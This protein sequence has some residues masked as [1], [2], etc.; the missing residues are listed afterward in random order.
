MLAPGWL[1]LVIRKGRL[2]SLGYTARDRVH[3]PS[4]IAAEWYNAATGEKKTVGGAGRV[5]AQFCDESEAKRL[6][7]NR[8]ADYGRG[9]IW[10]GHEGT[11]SSPISLDLPI[12]LAKQF[13]A[14]EQAFE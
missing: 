4:K 12:Q 10:Q 7:R 2:R 11:A 3:I 8:C 13:E 9:L 14:R 5:L 6:S 1:L